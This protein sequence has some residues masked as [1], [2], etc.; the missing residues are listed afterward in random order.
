MEFI[1]LHETEAIVYPGGKSSL[2]G[3]EKESLSYEELDGVRLVQN[4]QDEFF[5]IGASE[6]RRAFPG[7][8][9]IFLLLQTAIILWKGF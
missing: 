6:N 5:D 8:A 3:T 1:P 9:W 4:Y 2:Y 7:K